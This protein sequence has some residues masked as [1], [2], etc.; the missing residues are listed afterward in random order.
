M[1]T[2]IKGKNKKNKR[3]LMGIALFLVVGVLAYFSMTKKRSLN[4]KR[5]EISVKTVSEDY[6]E[7]FIVFQAKVE[8]LT[9]TLINVVEG[10]AVQEIF[11]ANG[12]IVKAGEPLVRLYNPNTELSYMNQ[13]T[14]MI[15]QINNLHK[16]RLDLRNQ[17]LSLEKDRVAIEHDYVDAKNEYDLNKQLFEK[18]ILA[19]NDWIIT[20]EKF[21]YQQERKNIIQ[22]TVAKEKE[23]NAIQ[24][25]QMNRS[26]TIMEK[27][28]EIL[29]QNKKNFLITA[30][31]TG[32]LSS[33]EPVLGKTYN[34]GETLG[35]IDVMEGYKLLADVDEFYLDKV[36]EHQKGQIDFKGE[37]IE[38][39]V[40]KVIQEVKGGRFMVELKFVTDKDLDLQQGLSFGVRLKLSEKEKAVVVSKGSFYRETAGK[41]I[42]KLEGDKAI[43]QPIELGRENPL[44]YEVKSGLKP[45][46]KVITS[47][48][49]DYK[50]VEVLN[51]N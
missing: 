17:E 49:E 24:L 11:V 31:F 8:P 23:A 19:K 43:R 40:T 32:R 21:R 9:S 37:L 18:E 6:F 41:W 33:F 5:G 36:S 25:A 7:D 26:L 34:A 2:I 22:Q 30:S 46:D 28:L 44:Y 3:V 47:N 13:E 12:D 15:E 4:I 27:S 14:S 50:K 42:F 48:Y 16:A 35:K 1:D 10:G 20:Q 51:F 45:G 39:E 38:V 29:R